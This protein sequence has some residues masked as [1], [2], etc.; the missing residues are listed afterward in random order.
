MEKRNFLQNPMFFLHGSKKRRIKNSYVFLAGS[1]KRGSE[2]YYI[3]I[4]LILGLI[5]LSLSLYFIFH[6]Y[7]TEDELDW[8]AC[9]QSIY[10]RSIAPNFKDITDLK[11]AFP[12]KC[13]TE[14]ITIDTAEPKVV[15]GKIADTIAAG[16][17]LFGEGEYDIV[18]RKWVDQTNY[19]MVF[20]RIHYSDKA[21]K[22]VTKI[23]REDKDL[24][25][26][27]FE[28]YYLRTKMKNS[29][30]TYNSYIPLFYFAEEKEHN[31]VF[32]KPFYEKDSLMFSPYYEEDLLLVYKVIKGNKVVS[33]LGWGIDW[34]KLEIVDVKD[35]ER[36]K[37]IY[38]IRPED[39]DKINCTEFITIPA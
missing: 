34:R 3:I 12:L 37:I 31:F 16:W 8:Q 9:R 14:V 7:F 26:Q 20:A 10:L 1:K 25:L 5:V 19:C 2:K 11:D 36:Y 18:P 17:Y 23:W 24:S 29:D 39:I 22:D 27:G 21:K 30:K 32:Y 4:S 33:F 15:Y 28:S 6:E 13:K 35:E 38:I